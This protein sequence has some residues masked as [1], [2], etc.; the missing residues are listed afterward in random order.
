MKIFELNAKQEELA[1]RLLTACSEDEVA[2]I[3]K[4]IA[5]LGYD[6]SRM[7]N[8]LSGIYIE[9]D[10][11]A[12]SREERAKSLM[13]QAKTARNKSN[14]IK[15]TILQLLVRF[16]IKKCETDFCNIRLDA[17]RESVPDYV[18]GEIPEINAYFTKTETYKLDKEKLKADLKQGINTAYAELVKKPFVVIK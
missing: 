7:I 6:A 5:S 13:Q 16:D 15:D 3:E 1:D 2:E 4:E 11:I 12:W 10:A 9:L 18:Y 14:Y 8:F 17:G